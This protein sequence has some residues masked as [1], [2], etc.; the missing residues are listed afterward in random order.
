[1]DGMTERIA[2]MIENDGNGAIKRVLKVAQS[3]VLSLL[4]E[5]MDVTKLDMTAERTENGYEL[6][7]RADVAR[8]YD[9]GRIA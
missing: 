2:K 7:I 8:F 1:M 5:F 6:C 9:V 3:D 4:N